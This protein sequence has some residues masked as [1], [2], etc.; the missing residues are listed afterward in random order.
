MNLKRVSDGHN[1]SNEERFLKIMNKVGD[2]PIYYLDSIAR[3]NGLRMEARIQE[4]YKLAKENNLIDTAESIKTH[5][6]E[7]YDPKEIK[8]NE[9]KEQERIGFDNWKRR[10]QETADK[11]QQVEHLRKTGKSGM[12]VFDTDEA[13]YVVDRFFERLVNK[14]K[15]GLVVVVRSGDT[16]V[17]KKAESHY[18]G[19]HTVANQYDVYF[20]GSYT[21]INVANVINDD[22]NSY[23]YIVDRSPILNWREAQKNISMS[24]RFIDVNS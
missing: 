10:K 13:L 11:E 8:E 22:S 24:L 20:N 1:L 19:A 4:Y 9:R 2:D 7:Q 14:Y 15:K 3:C 5:F 12:V 21:H 18:N 23:G 17:G 6:P 16:S